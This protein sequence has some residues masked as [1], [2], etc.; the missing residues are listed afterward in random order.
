MYEPLA[1]MFALSAQ[2]VPHGSVAWRDPRV[3]AFVERYV[4]WREECAAVETAY[5]QWTH[6]HSER[7]GR[8]LAFV[9]YRAALDRE[10]KAG[11]CTDLSRHGS[12]SDVRLA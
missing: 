10:E 7:L 3:D 11:A 4:A 1:R 5:Q 8:E 9:A 2:G 6:S 12:R